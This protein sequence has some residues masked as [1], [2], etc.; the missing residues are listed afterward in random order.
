MKIGFMTN[1][2]VKNG[3]TDIEDIAKFAKKNG[4]EDLEVGPTIELNQRKFEKVINYGIN[5]N[6]LTYCRNFLSS[7]KNESATH[8]KGLLDRIDFASEIGISQITTSTGINKKISEGIYDSVDSIRRRP[9]KSL[10]EFYELFAPI[11]EKAEKRNVKIAFEN[12]PLMG[13][14]AISPYM[15]RRIFDKFDCDYV[16][17]TYDPSHLIWEQI[18]PIKP[19]YEFKDKIFQIHAKD[20]IV[21]FN[22]LKDVGFLTDFSWWRYCIPGN[23]DLDWVAFFRAIKEIGFD[24]TISIE[25]EDREYEGSI[26]KVE[27]GLIK[28]QNYL[29]KIINKELK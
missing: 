20:T 3:L 7:D 29:L 28:S 27:E 21:N 15:W 6:S 12:C 9:E 4:F 19:L 25:H 26:E 22:L 23:G 10:D 24:Q 17:L 2:L 5:I 8:I 13:N 1:V 18:D 11:V 14:I 16:G